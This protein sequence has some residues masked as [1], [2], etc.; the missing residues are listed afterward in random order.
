MN[1]KKENIDYQKGYLAGY[2]AGMAQA[3]KNVQS[4]IQEIYDSKSTDNNNKEEDQTI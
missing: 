4:V 1:N 3:L 2:E